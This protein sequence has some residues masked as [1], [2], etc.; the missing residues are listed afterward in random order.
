MLRLRQPLVDGLGGDLGL[1][2]RVDEVLVVE[3]VACKDVVVVAAVGKNQIA[4]EL[5]IYK[6]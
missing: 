3:D 5:H 4:F 6:M 2:Q 1:G